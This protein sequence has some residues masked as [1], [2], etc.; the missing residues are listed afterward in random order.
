VERECAPPGQDVAVDSGG[1]LG[2]NRSV[3]EVQRGASAVGRHDEVVPYYSALRLVKSK[4]P[5]S[6]PQEMIRSG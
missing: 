6:M 5:P 4:D 3:A 1:Q 2:G